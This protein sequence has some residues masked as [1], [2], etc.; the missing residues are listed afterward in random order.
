VLSRNVFQLKD[1]FSFNAITDLQKLLDADVYKILPT[2]TATGTEFKVGFE[3][4]GSKEGNA[5]LERLFGAYIGDAYQKSFRL[6]D[7]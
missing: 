4:A 2:K 7:K 6:V 1:S 5:T 3:T